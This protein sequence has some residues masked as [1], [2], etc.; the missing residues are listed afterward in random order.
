MFS[1]FNHFQIRIL[2]AF[3]II[4]ALLIGSGY[5]YL[6]AMKT[7]SGGLNINKTEDVDKIYGYSVYSDFYFRVTKYDDKGEK[8]GDFSRLIPIKTKIGVDFKGVKPEATKN[9]SIGEGSVLEISSY[10]NVG[11]VFDKIKKVAPIYGDIVS[12]QDAAYFTKSFENISSTYEMLYGKKLNI[13][14]DLIDNY[15]VSKEQTA[16]PNLNIRYFEL[17]ED[18][19]FNIIKDNV[20]QPN[21][22]EWTFEDGTRIYLQY[23]T[24]IKEKTLESYIEEDRDKESV[25]TISTITINKD[26]VEPIYIKVKEGDHKI[27]TIFR[28]N[29]G[30]LY[31]LIL[32]AD[33]KTSLETYTNGYFKIALGIYFTSGNG[34]NTN[35][36]E[37]QE[38]ADKAY[39]TS[40]NILKNIK[41]FDE[42]F[43]DRSKLYSHF[44]LHDSA[45]DFLEKLD[46]YKYDKRMELIKEEYDFYP[47]ESANN[48]IRKE[49]DL[50]TL[51]KE[52]FDNIKV[53]DEDTD[54][55]LFSTFKAIAGYNSDEKIHVIKKCASFECL[56]KIKNNSW[57]LEK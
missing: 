55:G 42:T 16:I 50:K 36:I 1:K 51:V 14:P 12:T 56:I 37:E 54:G 3:S 9:S 2:I 21:I 32:L 26:I 48:A 46:K 19:T 57:E 39:V 15:Y 17:T 38:K 24:K 23:L 10:G 49:Q 4:V 47:S 8:K 45:A 40:E 30:Y 27:Q 11:N 31:N 53:P 20:W 41:E 44:N 5:Y 29:H 18:Y 35:F 28:D 52:V 43:E 7:V 33:N 34:F 13:S 22:A 6:N 25:V